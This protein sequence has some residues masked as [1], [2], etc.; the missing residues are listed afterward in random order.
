MP[1]IGAKTIN[2]LI[3]NEDNRKATIYKSEDI[4]EWNTDYNIRDKCIEHQFFYFC[5]ASEGIGK[6]NLHAVSKL[7]DKK[8]WYEG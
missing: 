7:V 6:G 5:Y 8:A 4:A 2:T 3:L 1:L